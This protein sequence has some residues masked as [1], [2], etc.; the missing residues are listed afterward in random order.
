MLNL[1]N[2]I[3]RPSKE[4]IVKKMLKKHNKIYHIGQVYFDNHPMIDGTIPNANELSYL[5]A[6]VKLY[7]FEKGRECKPFQ[8]DLKLRNNAKVH[9][10]NQGFFELEEAE[11]IDENQEEVGKFSVEWENAVD[12]LYPAIHKVIY[13]SGACGVL[14]ETLTIKTK[15]SRI[16]NKTYITN[17]INHSEEL[18]TEILEKSNGVCRVTDD[19]YF[20][21]IS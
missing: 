6:N 7:I 8:L 2:F 1:L 12:I 17:S 20:L 21:A 9:I 11:L 5:V 14:E 4:K 10:D 3:F 18:E 19:G 13:I 16:S 15:V